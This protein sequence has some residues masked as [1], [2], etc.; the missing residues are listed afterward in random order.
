M[1]LVTGA[2]GCLGSALVQSLVADGTRVA[3]LRTPD[4]CVPPRL[5]AVADRIEWRI[6]D[7]RDRASLRRAFHGVS[8][9][10]HL[11]GVAA[12]FNRLRRS[13][14]EVNVLGTATLAELALE[15]EVERFVYTSSS[16][17]IG[18]PDDGVIATEQFVYNGE[19][20]NFS[21]M[22]S[23]H[24]AEQALELYAQ[25]GLPVVMVNPT[26]VMA[27]G[28]DLRAN[29]CGLVAALVERRL[30]FVPDGGVAITTER[31]MVNGHLGAMAWGRPGERYILNTVNITYR[32]LV[33]LI[34]DVVGVE[35]PSMRAPA[36]LLHAVGTLNSIANLFRRDV[37]SCS[38][39]TREFVPLLMRR[40]YYDQSKAVRELRLSPTSLREAVED[41]YVWWLK[42][43][44]RVVGPEPML[45]GRHPPA[46]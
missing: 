5:H 12:P 37:M 11:A 28:G 9:I 8:H 21:Y 41:V 16:A 17:A 44:G 26:A 30:P 7:V 39:M 31:D 33:R 2:T 35:P 15:R 1:I 36:P 18:I 42:T 46:G 24:L 38:P 4:T 14:I 19:R 40:V 3:A 10:Y 32:D 34:A 43:T 22:H 13:M 29:W 23:K 27:P 6:G 25:R 20:F 45:M